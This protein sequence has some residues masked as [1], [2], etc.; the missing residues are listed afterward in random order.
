MASIQI[1]VINSSTVLTDQQVQ[2]AVPVLQ[3]QV[4][5]HFAPAWGIDADLTFVASGSQPPA[6]MWWL[7]ILNDSDQA[8]ALGYHELTNDGLPL[9][10]VFANTDIQSGTAWTLTSSHELLEMLADPD[11][12]LTTFVQDTANAGTLYAYEACDACEDASLGYQIDNVQ[13]SDFVYPAWFESFRQANSTRF[14]YQNQIRKPFQLLPGGYIG[15]FDVTAGDGW[16][17]LTAAGNHNHR[18]IGT[19]HGP[20][21]RSDRRALPHKH[22]RLS[23]VSIS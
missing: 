20:G 12:N 18:H 9:G 23:T 6:G 7:T 17:Q 8:G 4:H 2:A 14:D 10:K 11:I 3:K 16:R 13:V 5:E 19:R 22:W 15:A 1:A 21:S